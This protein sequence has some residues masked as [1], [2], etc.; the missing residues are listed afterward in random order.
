MSAFVV[1]K[2][3]I[4]V[5]VNAAQAGVSDRGL[6]WHNGTRHL[7][8]S[9]GGTETPGEVGAMLW[10]E[11]VASVNHRYREEDWEPVYEFRPLLCSFTPA[12]VFKAIDCYE[13]QSCE[14][15][16]WETSEAASFCDALRRKYTYRVDGY[17]AAP[18]D[19]SPEDLH[20]RGQGTRQ[21]IRDALG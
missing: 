2:E 19:W 16:G 5:L 18:W 7:D 9:G 17:S 12:E 20:R 13:Y 8:R 3:T 14:H 6:R 10:A 1:S 15:E 11:N 21:Q 4:D